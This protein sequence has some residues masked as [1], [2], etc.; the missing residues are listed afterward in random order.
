LSTP[1][2]PFKRFEL[3]TDPPPTELWVSST[4]RRSFDLFE[5]ALRGV[6]RP[7]EPLGEIGRR[8]WAKDKKGE[9]T[10][11]IW[12]RTAKAIVEEHERRKSLIGEATAAIHCGGARCVPIDDGS[13][14]CPCRSCDA[15]KTRIGPDVGSARNASAPESPPS[16][17]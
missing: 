6:G 14:Y 15:A 9:T 11:E 12:N 1:G 5:V 3:V 10:E 2:G 4:L 17:L 16:R 13:C 7:S 8:E